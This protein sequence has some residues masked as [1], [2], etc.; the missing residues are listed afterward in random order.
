V[1]GAA[2]VS[3][4]D[5]QQCTQLEPVR[6]ALDG[7]STEAHPPIRNLAFFFRATWLKSDPEKIQS[8]TFFEGECRNTF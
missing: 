6:T 2:G 4:I 7:A 3:C 1:S 8:E 5:R